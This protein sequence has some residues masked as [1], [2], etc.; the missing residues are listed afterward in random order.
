MLMRLRIWSMAEYDVD[1]L[2]IGGGLIGH[3]LMR[4]LS[5]YPFHTVLVD[6][7]AIIPNASTFDARN[8]A[9]SNASIQILKA[10]KVWPLLAEK[11]TLI[12]KIHVSEKHA[13]GHARLLGDNHHPLG[14]VVEIPDLAY[15]F[16]DLIA[17][18]HHV[19]PG[20]L[21][22]FDLKKNKATIKTPSGERIL[23][24]RIVV[25]AD[26]ANSFLRECCQLPL[27]M[28]DYNQHALVA[29]IGLARSH[30]H[31]AYERFTA[32]GP[33]AML[34]MSGSRASLIWVNSPK[35]TLELSQ[36]RDD[37][38]IHALQ[39]AFGYRMGR[40][41]KVGQRVVYPLHQKIMPQKVIGSVVFIGN[42]AHT[43]H[44]IAG[45]GFNLGLRDVAMLTQCFV[46]HGLCA[47]TLQQYQ[48]LRQSDEHVITRAT[49]T[50]IRLFMSQL[51][52]L[53]VIRSLGLV[54]VDNS[55]LLQKI[56]SRYASGY[57]GIVPDLVCGIPIT[58]PQHTP[59]VGV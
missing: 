36:L 15:A 9:L 44:P 5:P 22:A 52:G 23:R 4:A 48:R 32:H 6:D 7:R 58:P 39:L 3:A 24:A 47:E 55:L 2:I 50:L 17:K 46:K 53:S 40:F 34:P 27:Q 12:E 45:Q 37:E 54:A 42:A 18:E 26:G 56:L 16:D 49:D 41:V 38:L 35:K 25:G 13:F 59:S 51:P 31:W 8:I 10:L 30:H 29:N 11:V 20:K 57:G 19:R 21:I 43:L 14:G 1:I 33:I 28:K